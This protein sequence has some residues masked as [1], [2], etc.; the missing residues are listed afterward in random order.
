MNCSSIAMLL[1]A[2]RDGRLA[3]G[4]L[5]E[6]ER[7]VA[8]CPACR[9]AR[10]HLAAAATAWR[11]RTAQVA[12]PDPAGEWDRLRA[13]VQ[14]ATVRLPRRRRLAPVIWLSLPLAAAAAL[15]LIFLLPAGPAP[16]PRAVARAEFVEAGDAGTSTMVFVDKE[17][18]WLVVWADEPAAGGRG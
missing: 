12:V 10:A 9:E 17:S 5:A 3:P 7:H 15:A 13:R 14:D 6:L 16:E 4:E 1:S 8:A 11:T 18:G 2:E